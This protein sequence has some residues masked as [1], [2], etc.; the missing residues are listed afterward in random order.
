MMRWAL[1]S[2]AAEPGRLFGT[3]LGVSVAFTLVVFFEAVFEGESRKIIAYP[4]HAAADVWVMQ[5]G[6]SNMHMATSMIWDWKQAVV[7]DMKGVESATPILY[8][9][10]VV[11]AGIR[12][13]F[14]Y[15]VGLEPGAVGAG[16]WDVAAGK[17]IPGPGEVILPR[18]VAVQSGLKLGDTVTILDRRLTVS[19]LTEGTFSMA[20]SVTFVALRDL[21]QMM[22]VS[23]AYSYLLVRAAPGVAPAELADRI[24]A[25]LDDVNALPREE[26]IRNDHQMAVQMGV[27]VIWI[28]SLVAGAVAAIIV[29]FS[30]YT[31]VVSLRRDFAVTKSLGFPNRSVLAAALIQAGAVSLLGF[32]GSLALGFGLLPA[33]SELA[34]QIAVVVLPAH[35]GPIAVSALLVTI[36]AALLPAWAIARVDPMTV[37][38]A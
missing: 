22:D 8:T 14:S 10:A 29:A 24:R 18:V 25:E 9:N 26:F 20:N 6:V 5:G 21:E 35:Y 19:G 32:A 12:P 36:A 31:R 28:M 16:P 3:A 17:A 4:L 38:R 1:R 11:W 23:S 15:V 37:F 2:L 30:C 7:E 34:P 13:W 27:E 33:V